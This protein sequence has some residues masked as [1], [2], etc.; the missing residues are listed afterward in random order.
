MKMDSVLV[1]E[2]NE[3]SRMYDRH[4]RKPTQPPIVLEEIQRVPVIMKMYAM[5]RIVLNIQA[6]EFIT[7]F[8]LYM[9]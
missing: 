8:V 2:W 3:H 9:S 6:V 1:F 7:A 5:R 4:F